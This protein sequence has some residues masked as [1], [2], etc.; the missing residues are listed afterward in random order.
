M[1]PAAVPF[2]Y[3]HTVTRLPALNNIF[4]VPTVQV[5]FIYDE[6]VDI[7]L[8]KRSLHRLITEKWK[9]LGGRIIQNQAVSLL[10]RVVEPVPELN[11]VVYHRKPRK[12]GFT[13]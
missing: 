6:I 8:L 13:F 5:G 1:T 3:P 10:L 7:D 9:L 4:Q 11:Y 12:A 2:A